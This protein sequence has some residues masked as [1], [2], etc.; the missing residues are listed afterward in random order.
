LIARD[1]GRDA[2]APSRS[3]APLDKDAIA[4]QR[5]IE[6]ELGPFIPDKANGTSR[7]ALPAI[8]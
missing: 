3:A 4:T 8:N 6:R 5:L 7:D 1:R 2:D